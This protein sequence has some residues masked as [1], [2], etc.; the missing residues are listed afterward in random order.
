M[1]RGSWIEQTVP[2]TIGDCIGNRY[3]L[4]L[5]N[6]L[7]KPWTYCHCKDVMKSMMHAYRQVTG[8]V[9]SLCACGRVDI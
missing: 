7:Y 9:M 4:V 1:K 3:W 6:F 2:S 8:R 5:I